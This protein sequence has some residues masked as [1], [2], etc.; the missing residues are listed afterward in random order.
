MGG[1]KKYIEMFGSLTEPL[2]LFLLRVLATAMW[3]AGWLAVRH[4]GIVSKRL[5]LS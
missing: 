4:A 1:K 2:Y 3:L 5:N